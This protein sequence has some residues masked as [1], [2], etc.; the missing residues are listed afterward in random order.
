[1]TASP[2]P[3]RRLPKRIVHLALPD[4]YGDFSVDLWVNI[5]QSL[6]REM[7]GTD[8]DACAA[9]FGQMVTAHDLVDFNGAPYPPGGSP[10][11]YR[12]LPTDLVRIINDLRVA[13]IGRLSPP[14][15][16]S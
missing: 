14:S 16:L 10:D 6:W 1:L 9:A 7:M 15:A 8:L 4:P 12:E 5:P 3:S 13:Q 11:L 2:E